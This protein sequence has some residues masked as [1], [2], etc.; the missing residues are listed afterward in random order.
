MVEKRRRLAMIE[1]K[2][3]FD[4]VIGGNTLSEKHFR[5]DLVEPENTQI[6]SE[7]DRT[8][9]RLITLHPN[10]VSFRNNNLSGLDEPTK[11]TLLEDMYEVLG[12][13][14]LRNG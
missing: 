6:K 8:I 12:V 2:N 4:G 5:T 11:A 3:I 1:D 9:V 10:L 7:L 14:P 13:T